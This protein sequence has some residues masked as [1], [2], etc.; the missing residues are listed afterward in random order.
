MEGF[1]GTTKELHAE[2]TQAI[3]TILVGGQSYEIGS[4]KLTRADLSQLRAL[5]SELE[6][7][8]AAADTG[9]DLLD[10]TV[11]AMFGGR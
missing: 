7:E 1:S 6:E 10:N 3:R 2:V 5:R 8:M 11:V 9:T 4:R